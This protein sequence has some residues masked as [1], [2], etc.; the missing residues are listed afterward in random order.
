MGTKHSR[1]FCGDPFGDAGIEMSGVGPQKHADTS[2]CPLPTN[3]SSMDGQPFLLFAR[4]F[5]TALQQEAHAASTPLSYLR[6]QVSL[7]WHS[8]PPF[9]DML[10]FL[11]IA[12]WIVG[13][14]QD[15]NMVMGTL[16]SQRVVMVSGRTR[17]HVE[18]STRAVSWA[19]LSTVLPETCHGELIAAER[20]RGTCQ[21]TR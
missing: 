6:R 3:L 9:S 2:G 5:C 8:T 1:K 19:A 15:T 21:T 7:R 17:W 18:I 10:L 20:E 12:L 14:D 11:S 4:G 16:F 13:N